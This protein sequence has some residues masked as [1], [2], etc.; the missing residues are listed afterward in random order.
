MKESI[1]PNMETAVGVK[2]DLVEVAPIE[3]TAIAPSLTPHVPILPVSPRKSSTVLLES[4]FSV[5]S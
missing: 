5:G 1:L 2:A 3:K 4:P